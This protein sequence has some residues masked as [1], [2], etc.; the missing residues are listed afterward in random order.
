MKKSIRK[1]D[2]LLNKI[3]VSQETLNKNSLIKLKEQSV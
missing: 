1:F 2:H 3:N